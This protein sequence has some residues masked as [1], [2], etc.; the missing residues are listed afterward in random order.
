MEVNRT[1]NCGELRKEDKGKEVVMLGWVQRIRD[2]GGKKFVDL[3]DRYGI[4]QVVFGPDM[5]ENFGGFSKVGKEYLIEVRG[6]VKERPEGTVNKDLDTGSVEVHAGSFDVVSESKVPPFSIDSEKRGNIDESTRFKHRYL[7]LRNSGRK[8]ILI[9]RHR[10]IHRCRSFLAERDFIEVETPQLTKS[11]PEG[12]RDFL[13]PSRNYPGK[14]YALPQSP[15][16]F[17][18]LMMVSGFEKYYQ[19]VRCFR[20]ED[21]RKD[22]Q[23]EFTQLDIEISFS[24]QDGFIGLMEDMLKEALDS[25]YGVG[26]DIP[27]PRMTYSEAMNKYGSD[28]PDLRYDM[29]LTDLSDAVEDSKFNIFSE[30][31]DEGGVVKAIKFDDM[32]KISGNYLKKLEEIVKE[33]GA[34]GLIHIEKT[35]KGFEGPML[36]HIEESILEDI[37]ET[38]DLGFGEVL[39]IVAAERTVANEALG[40]LRRELGEK[41]GLYDDGDFE[42]VWIVDFPLFEYEAGELKSE[43]HPFTSPK[44][45]EKFMDM[46]KDTRE[47]FGSLKADAYD[48]VLNGFEIGGGSKR[49]YRKEVQEKVFDLLGLEEKE[50]EDRFGWFLEA[51]DYS[52]PPHR[53]IAYG[54]DRIIMLMEGE[55]NIREVIPFPKSKQGFDYLTGAPSEHREGQLQ[56]LGIDISERFKLEKEDV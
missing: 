8:G 47:R 44:D 34:A 10:F 32:E 38:M 12:A 52:A 56:G 55:P 13:V 3:R 36:D 45:T 20:D 31:V 6:E 27:F 9:N 23:P 53:G 30:T 54:L 51:F 28:R 46:D 18:Q 14:F 22:R 16:L 41:F 25:V 39:F 17:K 49:I 29:E 42:F 35:D 37:S 1:D 5:T 26:I 21:T 11:T 43:H 4:T 48:L 15:Q 2:H 7:D 50:V 19:V 33:E 24:D 40:S